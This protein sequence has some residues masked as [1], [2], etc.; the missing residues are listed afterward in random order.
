MINNSIS[1]FGSSKNPSD[2]TDIQAIQMLAASYD[3]KQLDTQYKN[4]LKK[5]IQTTSRESSAQ[6]TD[7]TKSSQMCTTVDFTFDDLGLEFI[8]EDDYEYIIKNTDWQYVR[9]VKQQTKLEK[10]S[11]VDKSSNLVIP[12]KNCT[13]NQSSFFHFSTCSDYIVVPSQKPPIPIILT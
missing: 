7:S 6:N 12:V 9:S 1:D 13:K 3:V 2:S 8:E 11:D 4:M 5:S 10:Y